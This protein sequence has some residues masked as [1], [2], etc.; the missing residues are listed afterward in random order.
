MLIFVVVMSSGGLGWQ[1]T[2]VFKM[3]NWN[4]KFRSTLRQ[5]ER[6]FEC[7][8]NL[9]ARDTR[10]HRSF[11]CWL[12]G[13]L[14]KCSWDFDL[15]FIEFNSLNWEPKWSPSEE[16]LRVKWW[17]SLLGVQAQPHRSRYPRSVA[18]PPVSVRT[19]FRNLCF[20]ER[21][22]LIIGGWNLNPRFDRASRMVIFRTLRSGYRSWIF[23]LIW[24]LDKSGF[25][26]DNV[27][28]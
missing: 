23:V 11:R 19:H 20:S 6:C 10:F 14:H 3:P 27:S 16:L 18:M 8:I 24:A 9:I 13:V 1:I 12:I 4:R 21:F 17:F 15:L 2:F 5:I 22:C 28:I 25:I 7:W 26:K